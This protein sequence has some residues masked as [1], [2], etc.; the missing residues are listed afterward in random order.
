MKSNARVW[1]LFYFLSSLKSTQSLKIWFF[2][3]LYEIFFVSYRQRPQLDKKLIMSKE[4]VKRISCH[5][6][7]TTLFP[8]ILAPNYMSH[9]WPA[10][11]VKRNAIKRQK[12]C[13][14]FLRTVNT[15]SFKVKTLVLGLINCK[16]L[17]KYDSKVREK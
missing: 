2:H 13:S 9:T 11:K 8:L 6:I 10:W 1:F 4:K 12:Q 14:Y 3:T 17:I 15:L 7:T 16:S 5:P